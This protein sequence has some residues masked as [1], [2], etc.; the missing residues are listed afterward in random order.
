MGQNTPAM[1][2]ESS[3]ELMDRESLI[4]P[5]TCANSFSYVCSEFCRWLMLTLILLE[6]QPTSNEAFTKTLDPTMAPTYWQGDSHA[7]EDIKNFGSVF[8]ITNLKTSAN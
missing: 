4:K 2:R 7:R 3:G 6:H 5:Y 1:T 8:A